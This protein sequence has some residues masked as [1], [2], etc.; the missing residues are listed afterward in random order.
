MAKRP[1]KIISSS[2][3]NVPM[4]SFQSLAASDKYVQSFPGKHKILLVNVTV[5][6]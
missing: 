6:I 3:L 2:E 4:I 5:G 1:S